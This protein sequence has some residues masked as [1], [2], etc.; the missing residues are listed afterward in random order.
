MKFRM[1]LGVEA[2]YSQTF[3]GIYP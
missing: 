2:M 1:D 3:I